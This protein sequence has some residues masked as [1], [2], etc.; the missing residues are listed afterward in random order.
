MILAPSILAADFGNLQ[1]D[2]EMVNQS[3]ADWFHIDIMDGVF[4]PNISYGMPV[5]EA[6]NKH[7]TKPLDV[8]LMIVDPDRYISTFKKLGSHILTVH[9]EA[10]T[11]LH[12]SVQA[13]KN[14][15]MKAG[16]ALNPH[17]PVNVLEDIIQEVDL[18]LIMSVNPGFGGQSFI[19]NTY[20]KIYQLKELILRNKSKAL[21]EV[22]GG[23]TNKNA[24]QL[25]DA[26]ADA[27]VAGSFVFN[28]S[29]PMQ[30]IEGMKKL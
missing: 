15:G 4:V 17:T 1:R 10:C 2:V 8:H 5:L 7:A 9:Y 24:R 28:S 11:H 20:K 26:G 12:R 16:V 30:T 14:E 3:L 22:D 27:L 19:E 18:V 23:V 21:I 25:M 6:I 13:I 29:N